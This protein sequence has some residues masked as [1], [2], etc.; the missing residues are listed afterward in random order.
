MSFE[1]GA[2]AVI[3]LLGGIVAMF[4][5]NERKRVTRLEEK[6]EKCEADH[7]KAKENEARLW[8][9]F[10]LL[11][12]A[13]Q[14]CPADVCPNKALQMLLPSRVPDTPKVTT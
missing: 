11:Q 13:I 6:V 12:R 1:Q 5:A 14:A 2:V 9:G 7:L 8:E 10:F 3:T 4:W